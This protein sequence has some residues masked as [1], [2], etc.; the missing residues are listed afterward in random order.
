MQPAVSVESFQQAEHILYC[1]LTPPPM[2]Q[3]NRLSALQIDAGN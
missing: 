1:Q 3:L 2:H